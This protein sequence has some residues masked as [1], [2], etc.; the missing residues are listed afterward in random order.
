MNEVDS[1]WWEIGFGEVW[2]WEMVEYILQKEGKGGLRGGKRLSG[3][4]SPQ[5]FLRGI[6]RGEGEKFEDLESDRKEKRGVLG[7]N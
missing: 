1:R 5:Q 6:K 3:S 2:S 7:G 4:K